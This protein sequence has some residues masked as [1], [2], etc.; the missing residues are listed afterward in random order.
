MD[1]NSICI[2]LI[3]EELTFYF[4]DKE[5]RKIDEKGEETIELSSYDGTWYDIFTHI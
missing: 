1:A 3:I 4:M 2:Q 5:G